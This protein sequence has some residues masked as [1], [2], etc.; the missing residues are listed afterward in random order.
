MLLVVDDDPES[1]RYLRRTLELEGYGV[2]EAA[3]GTDALAMASA[4]RPDGIVLDFDLG[5]PDG[6]QVRA[7]LR[8]Q[9]ALRNIPV[10][11][12][13]GKD[14]ALGEHAEAVLFKPVD[15]VRLAGVIRSMVGAARD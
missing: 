4:L 7:A 12:V 5:V 8:L 6:G 10:L 1:R 14:D 9:P 2:E 15:P 11:F 3:N 13:T